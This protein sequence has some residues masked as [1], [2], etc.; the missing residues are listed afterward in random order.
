[1]QL[2]CLTI[3]V[4]CVDKSNR[5]IWVYFGLSFHPNSISIYLSCAFYLLNWMNNYH[6]MV[7]RPYRQ[8]FPNTN[9]QIQGTVWFVCIDATSGSQSFSGSLLTVKIK[10]QWMTVQCQ[11]VLFDSQYYFSLEQFS[12]KTLKGKQ[13]RTE[14]NLNRHQERKQPEDFCHLRTH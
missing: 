11:W 13:N 5:T 8:E 6:E 10:S 2:C 12:S 9:A 3:Q 14:T 7:I 1:M 4:K